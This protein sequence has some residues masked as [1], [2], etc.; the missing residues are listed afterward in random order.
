MNFRDLPV[1]ERIQLVE[2]IWDSI[3][4]DSAGDLPFAPEQREEWHR[5]WREHQA[6]PSSGVPWTDVRESLFA[7]RR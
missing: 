2:D 3:A 7:P 1:S 6:D 4:Q 5:R